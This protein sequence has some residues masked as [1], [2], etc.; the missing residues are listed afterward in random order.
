MPVTM[1]SRH[2]NGIS[3]ALTGPSLRRSSWPA[4]R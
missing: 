2:V 3:R 1:L 4:D